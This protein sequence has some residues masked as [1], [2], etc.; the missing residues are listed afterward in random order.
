MS[1]TNTTIY[2]ASAGTGKTT[3]L[4]DLLSTC[5]EDTPPNRICFTTFTKAGAQEAIDRALVKNPKYTTRDFSAFSTLHALCFRR[6][7]RKQML[8]LQDYKLLGELTGYSI[9]G[10][11]NLFNFGGSAPI[12]TRGDKLLQ[13]N[14]VMRNMKQDA[15]ATLIN[16]VGTKF[17]SRSLEQFSQL[18]TQFKEEKNKYDFT[19]QLETF[20]KLG[21]KLEVDYLFV[22]EAQDLSPLQWDIVN[23]ISKEVKQVY[24]AGDD[25]QSIY[26]FSGG[27]PKSL[28]EYKGKRIVLGTTYRLS[29]S[30]LA[31]AEKIAEQIEDKQDYSVTCAVE[32]EEGSVHKIRSLDDL[33]LTKGTWFFL[34]RNR[35]MLP[36]FENYLTK[37]KLLFVSGG[38]T[39]LFNEKQIYNIKLWEQLRLGYKFK[40]GELKQLYREYLPTGSVVAR[41]SKNLLESMPDNE[42]YDKDDLAKDFG[43]RTTAKWDKV[44]KL[45]KTTKEILLKAESEGRFDNATDIEVNTIHSSKGREAENVVILPDLTQTSY[46]SY[47]KDEDNEHRVFYVACTR[48]KKNLYL[49]QPTSTRFYKLP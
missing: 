49:H 37:K 36:Y 10:M 4:M 32:N 35:A 33:D 15:A 48:A 31:Y 39:S 24:I 41:G 38:A 20:L 43:L 16:Q 1:T 47:V 9:S 46:Y 6:I 45:P 5:L 26:K 34:C 21:I 28:I 14:S 8:N 2:V 30:V 23:H 29:K 17:S 12:N 19:D 42:M 18:Y 25:K 44:F 7:P 11:S 40:A 27:D 13:Y 22:D 3:T